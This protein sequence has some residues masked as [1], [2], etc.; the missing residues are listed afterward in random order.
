M[1]KLKEIYQ[2]NNGNLITICPAFI[3]L[4][5]ANDISDYIDKIIY[6]KYKDILVDDED[7]YQAY[8]GSVND[9]IQSIKPELE[10]IWDTLGASYDPLSNYNMKEKEGEIDKNGELS[11]TTKRYGA[12]RTSTTIP[13]TK[14]SRYTTT[15]D[16]T[17][18]TRLE[19]YTQTEGTSENPTL[20]GAA[21]QITQTEQLTDQEG[22]K[23]VETVS[24]YN[25]EITINAPS[26]GSLSGDT[27][28]QREL[29]REGNIGV[30]TSQQ[31]LE[32]ELDIRKR[33]NFAEIFSDLF[34]KFN[35]L[36]VYQI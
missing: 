7:G 3:A 34:V 1:R 33:L 28:R 2:K 4:S 25:S 6:I 13:T 17:A 29:T 9:W 23:G 20:E 30:M 14:A 24:K 36:G 18:D 10:R 5:F 22:K 12:E 26:G 27:G 35:T 31:M 21:A 11:A 16:S 8:T 32:S 15:Y 19:S